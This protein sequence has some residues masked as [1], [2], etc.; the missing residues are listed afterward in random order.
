[1][2]KKLILKEENII[3]KL[4]GQYQDFIGINT[5]SFKVKGTEVESEFFTAKAIENDPESK[6]TT[7]V[8]IYV[9]LRKVVSVRE[10]IL[11]NYDCT[12]CYRLHDNT[13]FRVNKAYDYKTRD[14]SFKHKNN[15]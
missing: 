2:V 5:D 6:Y 8:T 4:I 10:Y 1:M 11:D 9:P 12:I 3:D 14:Y 13:K 15:Y 7:T